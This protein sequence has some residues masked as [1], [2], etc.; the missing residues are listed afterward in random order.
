MEKT[1][2]GRQQTVDM[3][4]EQDEEEERNRRKT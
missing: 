2:D 1:V 3:T 4:E